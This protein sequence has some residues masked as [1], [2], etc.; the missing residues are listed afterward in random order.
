MAVI[1]LLKNLKAVVGKRSLKKLEFSINIGSSTNYKLQQNNMWSLGS[2]TFHGTLKKFFT[3]DLS[4]SRERAER[5]IEM[6]GFGISEFGIEPKCL[7]CNIF[8]KDAIV[9]WQRVLP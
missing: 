7:Y 4:L 9:L 3:T 8:L 2:I 5:K 6:A 1:A